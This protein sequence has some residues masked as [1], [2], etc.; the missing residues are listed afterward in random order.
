MH[1][2]IIIFVIRTQIYTF[3]FKNAIMHIMIS[4]SQNLHSRSLEFI[5]SK[6]IILILLWIY[7]KKCS[8]PRENFDYKSPGKVTF[9][10]QRQHKSCSHEMLTSTQSMPSTENKTDPH[11]LSTISILGFY[12]LIKFIF[13]LMK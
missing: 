2:L 4:Y 11:F 13:L 7:S 9:L 12:E 1:T 6:L 5:P 8:K 3:H 10:T